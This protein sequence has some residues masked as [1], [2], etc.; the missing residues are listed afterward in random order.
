[1]VTKKRN[2]LSVTGGTTFYSTVNLTGKHI[3]ML[4]LYYDSLVKS[5][6]MYSV[7][8]APWAG[9]FVL[10]ARPHP[11]KRPRILLSRHWREA[12]LLPGNRF[13]IRIFHTAT[14]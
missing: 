4:E 3:A 11:G 12:H 6:G 10:K 5:D 1:M 13:H 9:C 8:C 14:S 7:T 2:A